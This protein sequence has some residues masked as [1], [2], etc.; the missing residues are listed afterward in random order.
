MKTE[1]LVYQHGQRIIYCD[2]SIRVWGQ[3]T[4]LTA[5]S[6]KYD[7]NADKIVLKG[8]VVSTFSQDFA[9]IPGRGER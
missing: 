3:G 9:A 1:H 5:K 4:E 6:A 7:L 2:Q 8:N